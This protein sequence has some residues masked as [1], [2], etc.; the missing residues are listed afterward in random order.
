MSLSVALLTFNSEK[1]LREVL[2]S[3]EGLADEIVA[4]D[5]GSTDSTL[6]ILKEFGVKVFTREFD[7]FVNQKNYLLS[8]TTK[9]WVLFLDD[10]EI[11]SK[12][13][14]SSVKEAIKK[15]KF[16]GYYLNRITNYLGRWIRHAWHPDWQLRLA[17]REK[18]R[19]V[20]SMVHE[21][22]KVDGKVGKLRGE[23]YH[24]SYS[25]LSE[26]LRKIDKYSTLYAKGAYERGKR[27]SLFKLLTS[28]AGT[29]LRRYLLK[30]GF[31]DGFEGFVLSVMGSY[32]S[33]LKYLKLWEIEKNESSRRP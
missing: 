1:K 33:F 5:S 20:G 21:S 30:R 2:K 23:L 32:Y 24:Y 11:L 17:K 27:F 13:L 25:S 3:V 12:E 14:Q 26:H 29:F 8:K 22:L 4:V 10:D 16:S 7:N 31:L 18:C 19:W 6:K 28:P 15:E 9:E